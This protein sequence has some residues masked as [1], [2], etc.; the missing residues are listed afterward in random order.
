MQQSVQASRECDRFT[1]AIGINGR[2]IPSEC[3]APPRQRTGK[4]TTTGRS[5]TVLAQ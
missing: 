3:R 4:V 5:V 2:S 1:N